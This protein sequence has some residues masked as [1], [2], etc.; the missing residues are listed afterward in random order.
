MNIDQSLIL[1]G[2]L[3]NKKRV[4]E[5][6]D[7]SGLSIGNVSQKLAELRASGYFDDRD[8]IP[9]RFLGQNKVNNLVLLA[10]GPGIRTLP[11]DREIPKSYLHV[12]GETLIERL[13]RQAKDAGIEQ[14]YV[15]VGYHKEAFEPLIDK[16]GVTLIVNSSY[17]QDDNLI[18]A[19]LAAKHLS[20]A[21]LCPADLYFPTNPFC[22]YEFASWYMVRKSTDYLDAVVGS[23]KRMAKHGKPNFRAVGLAYFDK[24]AGQALADN[25]KSI[26]DKCN[27]PSFWEEAMHG[28]K[29]I[30]VYANI[31][32]D[33]YCFDINSYED[34]R[35]VDPNSPDLV[36][37]YIRTILSAFE[38]EIDDIKDVRLMKKGMT[39]RS[40]L[41]THKG[42]E[43][44]MR[45]PGEGTE[46]LINRKQEYQAYQAIKSL[47]ISDEV[48]YM[49]PQSGVKITR[50][51]HGVRNCDPNCDDEVAL[52]IKTLRSFHER[53]V[54]VDFRFDLFGQ[55]DYYES[56]WGGPSAYQDYLLTKGKVL[57]LKRF[58]DSQ[59]K[60]EC[61]THIDAV[62]D[63]FLI[64]EDGSTR[65]IDW[66]YAANQDP[67]VDIA[68]F[69]IY[70]GYDKN[71]V[72]WLIDQYFDGGCDAQTR[73]KIYCYVAIC[74]LLWSNWCEYKQT[75]GVEFG[76]YS[77]NQ[78][79]YAKELSRIVL[80]A[81]GGKGQ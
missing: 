69:A 67:H 39:N 79:R 41:F 24:K 19:L 54:K 59:P 60:K 44:I 56:L 62:P 73:W 30:E 68:M 36:N 65:L 42:S 55:I 75:L 2:I 40:F 76:E 6:S 63:N 28:P 7:Y 8:Q 5:L 22:A 4:R 78:Y 16:Y 37:S 27:E 9:S 66:E 61:L 14:I 48:V 50:F 17:S 58:I 26:A 74:G 53:G 13:I 71:R 47:G 38:S 49:D 35:C 46:S 18:S 3:L 11:L 80:E 25:L 15:V 70:S 72:D 29:P 43:F 10:A 81:I 34:L 1:K 21:Y 23:K 32:N 33:G 45:L 64:L 12:N 51:V 20:R 52:C 57:E 77:L 31:V